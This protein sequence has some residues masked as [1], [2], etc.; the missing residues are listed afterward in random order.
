MPPMEVHNVKA[1]EVDARTWKYWSNEDMVYCP[2]E[3]T[4]SSYLW[5]TLNVANDHSRHTLVLVAYE[6]EDDGTP[7]WWVRNSWGEEFG[8]DRYAKVL[9]GHN[10]FVIESAIYIPILD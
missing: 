3:L 7:F 9:R 1:S 5:P 10:A 4:N 6:T 8:V 2:H